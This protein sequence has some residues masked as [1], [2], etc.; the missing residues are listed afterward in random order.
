MDAK[1]ISSMSLLDGDWL[2]SKVALHIPWARNH[3]HLRPR[4]YMWLPHYST[5]YPTSSTLKKNLLHL[6]S[7]RKNP[8]ASNT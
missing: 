7:L 8:K 2:R 1:I 5:H 6:G 3:R 4:L